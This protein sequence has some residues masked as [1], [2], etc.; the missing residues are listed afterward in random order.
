V[1]E[2]QLAARERVLALLFLMVEDSSEFVVVVLVVVVVVAAAV[3]TAVVIREGSARL[4]A[5]V[6]PLRLRQHRKK[7]PPAH[8]KMRHPVETFLA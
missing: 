8:Q 3:V 4:H 5:Q 2:A 7:Y 6:P 1:V